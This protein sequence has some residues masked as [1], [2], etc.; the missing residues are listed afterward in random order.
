MSKRLSDYSDR[1]VRGEHRQGWRRIRLG[2]AVRQVKDKVAVQDDTEYRL[3]GVRWYAFGAFCRETVTS[4][5]SEA[6]SFYKVSAGLLIYNRLFAWKGAFGLTA[7]E[8]EGAFVSGE[9]PLFE[10]RGDYD[11][12]FISLYLMQP[13]VWSIVEAQSTGAT[14]VSRN[15]WKEER[16]KSL[17]LMVPSRDRQ[18]A[19]ADE[20]LGI[21]RP[22]D[23]AAALIGLPQSP[24]DGTFGRRLIDYRGALI[25]ERVSELP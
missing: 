5:S 3:L 10:A 7:H 23:S 6:N 17:P 16:L 9:F 2:D 21:L 1:L 14:A 20:L 8:H 22:I 12:R 15:R 11:I 4:E 25:T 18:V 13:W 24:E 19:I